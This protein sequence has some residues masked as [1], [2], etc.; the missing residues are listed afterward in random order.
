P[1]FTPATPTCELADVATTAL[2]DALNGA[3]IAWLNPS[4]ARGCDGSTSTAIV[5]RFGS[6]LTHR[7]RVR[8]YDFSDIPNSS[9][10]VGI[11]LTLTKS[12]SGSGSAF[13]SVVT[14]MDGTGTLAP[15]NKA[16]PGAWPASSSTAYG[17]PSDTWGRSW[18]GA[19]VN[20]SGF[21][22]VLVA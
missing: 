18:T 8:G 1:T 2:D 12:R 11:T 9:T 14:L 17:G 22:W 21:G 3:P 10:V 19:D 15:N 6:G 16:L 4:N 20:A 13:D 7:L 5:H